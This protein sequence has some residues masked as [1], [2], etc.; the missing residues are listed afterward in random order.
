MRFIEKLIQ[1]TKN[2]DLNFVWKYNEGSKTYTYSLPKDPMNGMSLDA[3][4]VSNTIIFPNGFGVNF[5]R[6]DLDVLLDEIDISLQRTVTTIIHDYIDEVS[7][8]TQADEGNSDDNINDKTKPQ[9][10]TN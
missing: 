1:D 6:K 3:K 5:N 9:E 10:L 8:D 7:N 2:G 4:R